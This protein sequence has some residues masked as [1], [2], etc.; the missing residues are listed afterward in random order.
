MQMADPKGLGQNTDFLVKGTPY[1]NDRPEWAALI[2]TTK[3]KGLRRT[4]EFEN[5]PN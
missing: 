3:F 5:I 4:L 2:E 1:F